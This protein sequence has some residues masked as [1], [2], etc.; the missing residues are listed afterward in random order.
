MTYL[1]IPVLCAR[2]S[3]THLEFTA[4]CNICLEEKCIHH[5]QCNHITVT[6][7]STKTSAK[8]AISTRLRYVRLSLQPIFHLTLANFVQSYLRG[9][10]PRIGALA[11]VQHRPEKEQRNVHLYHSK[12]LGLVLIHENAYF[13]VLLRYLAFT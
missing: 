6:G 9:N 7:L 4:S 8:P 12:P 3:T 10:K 11:F 13:C 1:R 2:G 5:G